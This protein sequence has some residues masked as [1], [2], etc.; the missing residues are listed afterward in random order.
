M[1]ALGLLGAALL[2]FAREVWIGLSEHDRV[3]SRVQAP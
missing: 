3:S 2:E 1:L